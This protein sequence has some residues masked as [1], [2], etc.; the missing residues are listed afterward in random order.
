M[1]KLSNA[2]SV[3]SKKKLTENGALSFSE[4]NNPIITLFGQA[5]SLRNRTEEEIKKL[6]D[7]AYAY[8]AQLA[9][10][11][12]F[13]IGDIRGGLGERRTFRICLRRLATINPILVVMN[14]DN[15]RVYN[16]YDSYYYLI[17]TPCEDI[18]WEY[19]LNQWIMDIQAMNE[20]KKC[21]LLAKWLKSPRVSNKTH[22]K[23]A[24]MTAEHFYLTEA[25]YR[26]TLS[27]LRKYIDVVETKMSSKEWDKINYENVP[28]LAMVKYYGAFNT[29]D[30]ERFNKYLYDVKIGY[31]KMNMSV[32]HPYEI[33]R[34]ILNNSTYNETLKLAWDNL[35]QLKDNS[36]VLCF[37]D[38]SPSMT[39]DGERPLASSLGL[40][41]YF[42]QQNKGA[43]HNQLLTFSTTPK[44]IQFKD[45]DN[46]YDCVKKVNTS[47]WGSTNLY[48]AFHKLIDI[49]VQN[50]ILQEDMPD[51]II[52]ISDNEIDEFNRTSN[53]DDFYSTIYKLFTNNNY[54]PPKIIFMNVEARQT[55]FLTLNENCLFISGNSVS[56][57][58]ILLNN[59][60][61]KVMEMI[62]DLL[63]G[64]RYRQ[65]VIP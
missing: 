37:C 25:I 48:A 27:K 28:A 8:N 31:K 59:L 44:F 65:V 38:V 35:P 15:I 22:K 24:A 36:N 40:G 46:I 56:S 61:Y 3:E 4:A 41:I 39:W 5:G 32:T 47:N 6:F 43:F 29:H 53:I 1:N 23:W 55:T 34:K 58:P 60:S 14:M 45:S 26:K 21:T 18:M 49:S 62:E 64:P 13:Y 19:L 54:T 7:E 9:V 33:V 63:M 12:L 17:G 51:A 11:M 10:K 50:H 20:G 57:F 16:R 2:I 30:E 52:I 42:A